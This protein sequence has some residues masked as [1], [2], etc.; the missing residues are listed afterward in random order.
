MLISTWQHS[1]TELLCAE[2]T[3][4]LHNRRKVE[5]VGSTVRLIVTLPMGVSTLVTYAVMFADCMH[6]SKPQCNRGVTGRSTC[7]FYSCAD[8]LLQISR[9]H[10]LTTVWPGQTPVLRNL[11]FGI[12]SSDRRLDMHVMC[13]AAVCPLN[14]YSVGIGTRLITHHPSSRI[15]EHANPDP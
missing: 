8:K 14:H 15:D 4:T 9:P 2:L 10:Y 12:M 7:S 13:L 5:S 6:A 11:G 3:A 1:T